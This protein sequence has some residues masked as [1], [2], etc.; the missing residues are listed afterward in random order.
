[1][2]LVAVAYLP[3]GEGR[4]GSYNQKGQKDGRKNPTH[5]PHDA[6]P[7]ASLVEVQHKSQQD[8]AQVMVMDVTHKEGY[9]DLGIVSVDLS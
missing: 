5:S 3:V 2:H 9:K 1:V 6:P 4:G 7:D 8:D